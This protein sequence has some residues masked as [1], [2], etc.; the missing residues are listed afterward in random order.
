MGVLLTAKA[1]LKRVRKSIVVSVLVGSWEE[2]LVLD[3][4]VSGAPREG[5]GRE[6]YFVLGKRYRLMDGL[7]NGWWCTAAVVVM[8]K[9]FGFFYW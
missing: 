5:R 9:L 8:W 7:V 4:E 2:V 1:A 3:C 6:S